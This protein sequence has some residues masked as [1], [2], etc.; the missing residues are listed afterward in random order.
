MRLTWAVAL[1]LTGAVTWASGQVA[2]LNVIGA[3]RVNQ[4]AII[5]ASGIKLGASLSEDE[6]RAAEASIDRLGFF[7][8]VH[9]TKVKTVNGE[10]LVIQVQEW[11][12]VEK[13][14]VSG[15]KAIPTADILRLLD[16]EIGKIFNTRTLLENV[17][18]VREL[19]ARRGFFGD[20][21]DIDFVDENSTTLN[22][23]VVEVTVNSVT[24]Y[25]NRR[26][27]SDII[28]RLLSTKPGMPFNRNRWESD[29]RR[30][31]ATNWFKDVKSYS[32]ES[33]LGKVDLVPTVE[34][35]KTGEW[36]AGLSTEPGSPIVGTF[37]ISEA[38]I[39]GT[40][41]SLAFRGA[42]GVKTNGPTLEV[43]YGNPFLTKQ[44][45]NFGLTLYTRQTY[46][47]AGLG[48]SNG[49]DPSGQE[50]LGERRTGAVLGVTKQVDPSST[51][52]VGIRVED[53][54]SNEQSSPEETGI[55]R[56]SGSLASLILGF[57]RNRRDAETDPSRGDWL[58]L[59]V[60]PGFSR[61]TRVGGSLSGGVGVG[62]HTF[63]KSTAEYRAYW[64][65]DRGKN[66][67][68]AKVPSRV[69]ALRVRYGSLYGEAPFS[70]QFFV[71]GTDT[72]RGYAQDRFWGNQMFISTLEYRHPITKD[73]GVIGF[74]D[75]GGAWGG[76]GG[77]NNFTQSRGIQMNL[78]Y[79]I[80]I[81]YRVPRIGPLRLDFG[82]DR[83]GRV[84]THF[85]I[86]TPF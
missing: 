69:Y 64:S 68:T 3:T 85:Q 1:V 53:V 44:N 57:T 45:L 79:G 81:N 9:I 80:G 6:L 36:T 7:K 15:N 70:E 58:K 25:G 75:Y 38:N 8:A 29:M 84:R 18:H 78:G 17:R 76:Y 40:G 50:A 34:E 55:T 14:Q 86:S 74:V 41:Q 65:P 46:R 52:Q 19:Y 54:Q 60:E 20:I 35:G 47:F 33:S 61:I 82:V 59:G 67:E 11:P 21:Q 12:I 62:D 26:T 10:E 73:M 51:A 43:S 66:M 24:P 28:E 63:V 83:E 27:K 16:I 77:L 5:A 13:V 37:G 22:V 48:V 2:R 42:Q 49:S 71:G 30:L 4:E 39:R 32:R 23:T 72:V 31:A 56:Q